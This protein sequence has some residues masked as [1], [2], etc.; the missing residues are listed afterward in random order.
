MA[1]ERVVA[2]VDGEHDPAVLR[3]ALQRACGEYE[4]VGAVLLG[5]TEKLDGLPD[6]GVPL[7]VSGADRPAAVV[8]AAAKYGAAALLDLSDEPV[9]DEA[10]RFELAAHSLAAGLEYRGPDFVFRPPQRTQRAPRCV[11]HRTSARLRSRGTARHGGVR[12]PGC[13]QFAGV[14]RRQRGLLRRTRP[15][16]RCGTGGEH[17][18]SGPIAHAEHPTHANTLTGLW[19]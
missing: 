7:E 3:A 6:L 17:P 18:R 12:D 8:A 5:G 1:A 4:V 13:A 2:L 16:S 19:H 9:L 14:H 10:G 15:G 11:R